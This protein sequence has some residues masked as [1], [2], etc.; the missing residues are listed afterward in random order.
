MAVEDKLYNWL[1]HYNHYK[2]KWFGFHRDDASGYFNGTSK[3][4]VSDENFDQCKHKAFLKE[5]Q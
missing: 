5:I 3:K 1:F 4:V 2:S